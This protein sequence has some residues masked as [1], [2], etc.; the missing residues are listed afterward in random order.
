MSHLDFKIVPFRRNIFKRIEEN[1]SL[2]LESCNLD[3]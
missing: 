3:A 2:R 1:L